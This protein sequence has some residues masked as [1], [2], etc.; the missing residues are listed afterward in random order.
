ML[1]LEIPG[2]PQG[3]GRLRH[4]VVRSKANPMGYA[5]GYTPSKTVKY[6]QLIA[7]LARAAW[8]CPEGAPPVLGDGAMVLHVTAYMAIPKSFSRAKRNA[9]LR[10]DLVPTKKP[11][12]DNFGKVVS[13]ALNTIAFKDD[14]QVAVAVV[15]KS[16]SDNPRMRIMVQSKQ[17]TSHAIPTDAIPASRVPAGPTG[18]T[19][20]GGHTGPAVSSTP[21]P[22]SAAG[23]RAA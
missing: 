18:P 8:R 7:D 1:E 23:S 4:R 15:T 12:W 19:G 22:D 17:G 21:Y 9:A 11:D 14:A 13:D 2:E 6:Q 16:Y 20:T 5:S 3:K 10:G